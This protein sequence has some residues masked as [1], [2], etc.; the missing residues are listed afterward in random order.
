VIAGD[1]YQLGPHDRQLLDAL[2]KGSYIGVPVVFDGRTWGKLETFANV[3]AMPF[4]RRHVPFLEAIAGQVG[5]AI[6]R[7]ELFSRVNALA[8][9]DPL[10]GLGNRRALDQ[11][12]E[13][14]AE[15][16]GPLAIAFCDLDRLKLIND[17]LGHEAGDRAIRRTADA[18]AGAAHS[19]AGAHVY[20]VGG[21]EFCVVLVGA[22]TATAVELATEAGRTL[23]LGDAP[24][25]LSCG[26]AELRPGAS[27]STSP[28]AK[29]VAGWWSSRTSRPSRHCPGAGRGATAR[30][31][32]RPRSPNGFWPRSRM[33][34]TP[35]VQRASRRPWTT[36]PDPQ[37]GRVIGCRGWMPKPCARSSRCSSASPI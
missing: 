2:G 34:R 30:S 18:L 23:A 5:A 37:A 10:T 16:G 20:R 12:L 32:R 26:V 17:S 6:G 15:R 7:A 3:G 35:S 28:S 22:G 36:P 33:R 4:T 21:D 8:Y 29:A 19:R 11:L 27:P 9:A 25:A 14:A 13:P 1:D 31:P 24:L